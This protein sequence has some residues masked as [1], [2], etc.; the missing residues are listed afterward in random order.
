VGVGLRPALA[1]LVRQ[2][3]I[4]EEL[5]HATQLKDQQPTATTISDEQSCSMQP[6]PGE[7]TVPGNVFQVKVNRFQATMYNSRRKWGWGEDVLGHDVLQ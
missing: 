5:L 3:G 7:G 1:Y 6:P 4:K 2:R